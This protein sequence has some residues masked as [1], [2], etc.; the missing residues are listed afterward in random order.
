MFSVRALVLSTGQHVTPRPFLF[1][2]AA[3]LQMAREVDGAR[4]ALGEGRRG[5]QM[6]G[7]S[8]PPTPPLTLL[9]PPGWKKS[10]NLNSYDTLDKVLATK[11]T[12][13]Y[14]GTEE[15]KRREGDGQRGV[16]GAGRGLLG[17]Q[18]RH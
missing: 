14:K 17:P 11:R 13:L 4:P 8:L 15:H 3:T 10:A 7:R 16:V 9:R 5:G 6:R 18:T 1:P 2:F 12:G